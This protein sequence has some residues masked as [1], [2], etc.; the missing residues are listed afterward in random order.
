MRRN[1]LVSSLMSSHDTECCGC[2]SCYD[3]CPKHCISMMPDNDG[4]LYPIVD[5]SACVDCGQCDK[6]CPI[7]HP[8]MEEKPITTLAVINRD[9]TIRLQSSSGGFFH[10]LA[11]LVIQKSG[12]VFGARFDER[13]NVR[14]DCADTIE[15]IEKFMGAKYVQADLNEAYGKVKRYLHDDRWVLF[16]GLPCQVSGLNHFL[17]HDYDKLITAECV[18]H[19][20][21]SPKVWNGYVEAIAKGR[22]VTNVN[23]RNKGT[24]WRHY[25]YQMVVDFENGQSFKALSS[26]NLYMKGLIQNLT[27][28]PSCSECIAKNGRSHADFSMGDY[29]GAWDLQHEM[30][31][32]KG[33]SIVV[34]HTQKALDIIPK[35]KVKAEPADLEK[36]KKYN[37]GLTEPTPLHKNYRRFFR[38]LERMPM[39]RLLSKYLNDPKPVFKSFARRIFGNGT[40]QMVKKVIGRL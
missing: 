9:E 24:G 4:F 22:N 13:W 34:V 12:V 20:V 35:L 33:T 32:D 31:D 14:I 3:A 21:P 40:I 2:A 27:T 16:T 23:F 28:R 17:S 7:R 38:S 39:D 30:D 18:C 6:V 5:L 10:A 36:A 26:S 25:A 8:Y 37:L 1:D 29:W 19:S 15:G 11:E